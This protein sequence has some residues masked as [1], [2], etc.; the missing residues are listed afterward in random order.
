MPRLSSLEPASA[1]ESSAVEKL[2]AA[3]SASVQSLYLS[4]LSGEFFSQARERENN[5]VYN[6][7]VVML[8]M[9]L[10]RLQAEGTGQP[11]AEV[12]LGRETPGLPADV[13]FSGVELRTLRA[14]AKKKPEAAR[15][16]RRGGSD[17]RQDRWISRT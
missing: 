16:A 10:Q 1:G 3:R 15:A 7:P 6:T 12:L 5:R 8:L 11:L 13:L 9:I 2:L 14:Y 4:L 17:G